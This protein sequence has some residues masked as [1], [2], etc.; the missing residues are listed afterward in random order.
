MIYFK[1][2]FA[3][4]QLFLNSLQNAPMKATYTAALPNAL[5]QKGP[6]GQERPKGH[7]TDF[8]QP[9]LGWETGGGGA[10]GMA[11]EGGGLHSVPKME[12]VSAFSEK[13]DHGLSQFSLLSQSYKSLLPYF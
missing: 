4:G 12:N 7:S 3:H 13:L 8:S 1:F 10:G 9:G 5:A 6:L 11:A 2:H